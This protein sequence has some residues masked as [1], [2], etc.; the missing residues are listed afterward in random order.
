VVACWSIMSVCACCVTSVCFPV[1]VS[2]FLSIFWEK[3]REKC[4]WLS[5]A[6]ECD[7][8]RTISLSV[9]PCSGLVLGVVHGSTRDQCRQQQ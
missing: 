2:F 5:S 9:S 4:S 6:F 1:F 8:Q 3:K 7:E